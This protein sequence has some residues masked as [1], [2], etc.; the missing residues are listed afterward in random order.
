MILKAQELVKELHSEARREDPFVI[1]P[2]PD[3][4]KLT[5]SGSASIDLRLGTWFL[6]LPQT[7]IS[8]VEVSDGG[9][10]SQDQ[11]PTLT[12]YVPFGKSFTLHPRSFVLGGTMEW[13]RLPTDLAGYVIGRSSWGRRGL[14]IATATGVHPGFTGCLTLELGNVG[15]VPLEVKPGMRICQLFVHT[16][17]SSST[18]RD[19]SPLLARRR[20]TLI[21]I[22]P[23]EIALKLGRGQL[24]ASVGCVPLKS[25]L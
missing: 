10:T 4:E 6:S 23:D 19:L 20:P 25:R 18:S 1:A 13:I 21:P 17:Q 22:K 14:I 12:H 11:L 24:F 15:E 16:V 7:R 5:R 8:Q 2:E 9:G 3:V